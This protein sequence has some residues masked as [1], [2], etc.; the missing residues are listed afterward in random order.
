MK[1]SIE[2]IQVSMD[3]GMYNGKEVEVKLWK[4]TLK[5]WLLQ[6]G[7]VIDNCSLPQ[8]ACRM[9][10]DLRVCKELKFCV[11]KGYA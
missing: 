2:G 1:S 3:L 10:I 5:K 6:N 8:G 4:C 9:A 11:G 7:S